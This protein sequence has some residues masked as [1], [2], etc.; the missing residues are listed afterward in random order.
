MLYC[1]A[2]YCIVL[3]CT[4]LCS[5]V[6]YCTVLYYTILYP[7]WK[8]ARLALS[9]LHKLLSRHE[10]SLDDFIDQS[11]DLP[12]VGVANLPKPPGH[13][14]L[15]HMLSDS[16]LLRKVGH[17]T[18][19]WCV[20]WLSFDF[21]SELVWRGRWEYS[22]HQKKV[23]PFYPCY[24]RPFK[25]NGMW[26]GIE[27]WLNGRWKEVERALNGTGAERNG[28]YNYMCI[29]VE[30]RFFTVPFLYPFE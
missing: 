27:R 30:S 10:F 7:Q 9:L 19:T 21:F 5:N 4:V 18:V 20:V 24:G 22:R 16:Q 13:S 29:S 28:P 25:K 15:V 11:Y 23:P 8:V 1:I 6:L 12:G 26:T 17:V 14:I 2:L 3:Y